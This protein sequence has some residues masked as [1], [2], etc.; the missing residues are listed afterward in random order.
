MD[1]A[2]VQQKV[3]YGALLADFFASVGQRNRLLVA[4]AVV[5]A[6]GLVGAPN[7]NRVGVSVGI[8]L[9]TIPAAG[10]FCT[11]GFKDAGGNVVWQSSIFSKVADVALV[12]PSPWNYSPLLVNV[13]QLGNIIQQQP[14][15]STNLAPLTIIAV[16]EL[17][18]ASSP[19][20]PAGRRR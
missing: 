3:T 17:L 14:F 6:N 4:R 7:A 13:M 5:V 1:T 12:T 2:E 10:G 16:A 19:P 18:F 11:F 15:V 9:T 8:D 20:R